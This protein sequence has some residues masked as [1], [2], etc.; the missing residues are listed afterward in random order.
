MTGKQ[1]NYP[2]TTFMAMFGAFDALGVGS[3]KSS[4]E[5]TAIT[6]IL[7][8]IVPVLF[9]FLGSFSSREDPD[10][11]PLKILSLAMILGYTL[12]SLYL[13]Y[14]VTYGAPF[15]TD[16]LSR[17]IIPLGQLGITI[18]LLSFLFGYAVLRPS[19][20]ARAR[21]ATPYRKP[22]VPPNI[23]YWP[24]LFISIILMVI[25]F[26]NLGFLEQILTLRFEATK[27]YIDADGG[28]STLAFLTIGADFVL[29]MFLYYAVFSKKI[30]LF[31]IYSIALA[32]VSLCHLMASRRNGL[33][34]AIVAYLLVAGIRQMESR[35]GGKNLKWVIIAFAILGLVFASGVRKGGGEKSIADL[36][37]G[38]S[39]QTSIEHVFEGAYFVDPGKT[40]AI[41]DQTDRQDIALNG[42]SFL[43]FIVAPIPRVLW[44][45]KPDVRIGPFVAQDI[46]FYR[47]N[48]GVPPGGIGELYLNFGWPGIVIGMILLGI[49]TNFVMY[50]YRNAADQRFARIPATMRIIC[51][52][53]FLFGDFTLAL[54]SLI[55]YEI[56]IWVCH[57]FWQYKVRSQPTGRR[58]T[59][60]N[61]AAI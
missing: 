21:A 54:L 41:I 48:S 17:D 29:I 56:A 59:Q 24:F 18:G 44:P 25:Y 15:R 47:N 12:K 5:M 37:I 7:M 4:D 46:L 61:A 10:F 52:I 32:F 19:I 31:S 58:M 28:R 26:V 22:M 57:R 33:M 30:S 2:K 38:D 23:Y 11:S 51:V 3:A 36:T 16:Y 55:R 9:L 53:L 35:F 27:R 49:L 14:A 43:N 60:Q 34:I 8:G 39:L 42:S 45:D 50:K 40:A 1:K 13:A 20:P 6:I